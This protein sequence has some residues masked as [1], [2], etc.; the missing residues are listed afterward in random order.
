M[1]IATEIMMTARNANDAMNT[2]EAIAKNVE[3]NWEEETTTYLFEDD[4]KLV[5]CGA[6]VSAS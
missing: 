3:Q 6:D 4:S 5:V 2:A 1:S